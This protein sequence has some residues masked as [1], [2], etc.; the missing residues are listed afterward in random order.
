MKSW[1]VLP[2]L[3]ALWGMAWGQDG[4]GQSLPQVVVAFPKDLRPGY[5][6]N[7]KGQPEGFAHDAMEEVARSA[8]LSVRYLLVDTLAE[9]QEAVKTGRAQLI[10]VITISDA[11][12][13]D[14]DFSPPL[15]S[16][17]VSVFVLNNSR[18][19]SLYTSRYLRTGVVAG[20]TAEE[21][22]KDKGLAPTHYFATYSEALVAL[23]AGELD[24]LVGQEGAFTSLARRS[25]VDHLIRKSGE[26][27]L[28]TYRAMAVAK[29][30]VALMEKIGHVLGKL[31]VSP[32]YHDIYAKWYGEP[33]P[34]W[35]R[36][37][38]LW[39]MSG[40]LLL[41]LA[42][43]ALWRFVSLKRINALL[44]QAALER[45]QAQALAKAK[46]EELQLIVD[47]VPAS[48]WFK[49]A[50][51]RFLH[52]NHEAA[53]LLGLPQ[54]AIEGRHAREIFPEW[55]ADKYHQDDLEVISR[56][57]PK[58]GIEEQVTKADGS[59]GWVSTHKVPWQDPESERFGVLAL[60]IDIT[61]RKEAEQR[62]KES[63]ER[64]RE[65]A[66]MLPTAI[67][68]IDLD[69]RLTFANNAGLQLLGLADADLENGV[70]MRQIIQPHEMPIALARCQALLQGES[71][72]P[73]EYCLLSKD[74]AGL[75]VLV[76]SRPVRRNGQHTGFIFTMA[77]LTERKAVEE[78]LLQAKEELEEKVRE[79]TADLARINQDLK[80]EIN[81][82]SQF[83]R[84]LEGALSVISAAFQSTADGIEIVDQAGRMSFFNDKF[85][86]MW[87]LPASI[88][89]ARDTESALEFVMAQLREP[90]LL[91]QQVGQALR[92][93]SAEMSFTLELKDGRVFEAHSLPQRLKSKIIGRVWS[94]RDATKRIEAERALRRSEEKHRQ[95]VDNAQE[96]IVVVRDGALVFF[97]PQTALLTDHCP[98]VLQ[99]TPLDRLIHED[100]RVSVAKAQESLMNGTGHAG[101]IEFRLIGK[102]GV[103]KWVESKPVPIQWEGRPAT[104]HLLGDITERKEA[105]IALQESIRALTAT[106]VASP[107]GIGHVKGRTLLWANEAMYD[108]L[109][110]QVHELAGKPASILYTDQEEYERVGRLLY[111]QSGSNAANSMDTRFRRKDGSLVDVYI[112]TKFIDPSDV[113]LGI[114]AAVTDIS[115]RK[116]YEKALLDY[117]EQLRRL[118]HELSIVEERERRR[119]ASDLHDSLGQDL[120]LMRIKLAS[121]LGESGKP[122]K[123]AL[124]EIL[125]MTDKA[126]Q[127]AKDLTWDLSAPMLREL[128]L[129]PALHWL[130]EQT[131]DNYGLPT[132]FIL[133]GS[134]AELDITLAN[135]LFRMARELV[136]NAIKHSLCSR[137][138][139]ILIFEEHSL[140]LAVEDDGVGFDISCLESERG[141]GFGLFNIRG[142]INS[143]GGKNEI[144]SQPG[145]GSRVML[146]APLALFS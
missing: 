125:A 41:T 60:A 29:G 116:Q 101:L 74:G 113:S 95:V 139:I 129:A 53:R 33:A 52:V 47:T 86:D 44:L 9:A 24:A 144:V 69:L 46:A 32:Q 3:L 67:C 134:P 77:D 40:L 131:Q 15:M 93:S 118:I 5:F 57:R 92:L 35:T 42:A 94:F 119:I 114:I 6:V 66:E 136:L 63:E 127:D 145:R 4:Q 124:E 138:R 30:N 50:E 75:D 8:G 18:D 37:K 111:S 7:A 70:S 2:L 89:D 21:I 55:L 102:D 97:N 88:M 84:E 25:K 135:T 13:K 12:R 31:V 142:I 117:Q 43:M 26:P 23:L 73:R 96:A 59:L 128:G 143:W 72:S 39:A 81:R 105:A 104:L 10:P 90:E 17:D 16:A 38:L 78:I 122:K 107:V 79:R 91:R 110:Y 19:I 36:G 58:L 64:F 34:F 137:I 133:E 99:G 61:R 76:S 140:T 85:R 132:D 28:R 146:V 80:A 62:L 115:Q 130:A 109:Q 11:R 108:L 71:V 126:L 27:I 1:L 123:K 83:E 121:V 112:K 106:L 65:M 56:L 54:S 22:L 14:L 20:T 103:S 100:D 49:D 51:N 48:I 141:G 98:S 82:R 68:E 45:G 87:S 120:A